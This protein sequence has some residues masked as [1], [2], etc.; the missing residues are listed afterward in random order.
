[1]EY[2]GIKEIRS[3]GYENNSIIRKRIKKKGSKILTLVMF[4]VA[5]VLVFFGALLLVNILGV[6][7]VILDTIKSAFALN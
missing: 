7:S 1:M 5:V 2:I 4:Q 3:E 6:Q